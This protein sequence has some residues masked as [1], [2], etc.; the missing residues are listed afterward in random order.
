MVFMQADYKINDKAITT[1]VIIYKLVNIGLTDKD[2]KGYDFNAWWFEP[3][4]NPGD[5]EL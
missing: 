1:A 5:E 2:N 4:F 3:L